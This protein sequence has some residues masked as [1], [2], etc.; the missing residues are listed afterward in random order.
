ML[1]GSGWHNP[2]L[3]VDCRW[4]IDARPPRARVTVAGELDI[5]ST[6]ALAAAVAPLP[7]ASAV[8]LV[9]DL[10]AVSFADSTALNWL[11]GLHRRCRDSDTAILVHVL[12]T[13]PVSRL[14]VL[15]GVDQNVI[16]HGPAPYRHLA[17]A[18]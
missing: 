8:T 3:G 15:A 17:P 1:G 14:L 10:A 16:V 2:G 18:S 4:R 5:A 11:L 12:A 7:L 9:V 6:P 13:G